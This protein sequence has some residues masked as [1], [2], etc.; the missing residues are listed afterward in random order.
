MEMISTNRREQYLTIDT[1]LEGIGPKLT[2]T[3]SDEWPE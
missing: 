3:E 2:P 1:Y